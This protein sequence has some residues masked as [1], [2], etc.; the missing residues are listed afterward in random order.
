MAQVAAF[1]DFDGTLCTGQVWRGLGRWAQTFGR[2]R[3]V[4]LLALR[5]WPGVIWPISKARLLSE[6]AFFNLWGNGVA[7]FFRGLSY[8]QARAICRW[9]VEHE[10]I[11]TLRPDVVERLRQHQAQG[12]AVVLVSGTL[13]EVLAEV[14]RH[15]G[16][17]AVL[18]TPLEV[19][20]GICTGR[21]QGPFLYGHLKAHRIQRFAQGYNPPLDLSLCWAYA[22]RRWD[23]PFLETAGLAVAVYPDKALLA[24][25]GKK[26]WEVLGKR[27]GPPS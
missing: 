12:H 3:F 13:Q 22:D 24:Y 20:N 23:I 5:L 14:A 1:F 25:A 27:K 17:S 2:R 26:G 18:A 7:T 15:L 21:L 19:C 8:A 10:I 4:Y 6:G 16:V 11:P 9:V